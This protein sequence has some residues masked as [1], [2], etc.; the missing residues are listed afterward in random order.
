MRNIESMTPDTRSFYPASSNDKITGLTMKPRHTRPPKDAEKAASER[1]ISR[2][3]TS[4]HWTALKPH[5]ALEQ[6]SERE[7]ATVRCSGAAIE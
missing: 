4:R 5:S 6:L 1:E 7:L 2:I 3:R